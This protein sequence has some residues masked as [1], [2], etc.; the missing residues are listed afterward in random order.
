VL[1]ESRPHW[2][3]KTQRLESDIAKITYVKTQKVWKLY[4]MRQD[5]K[6]HRYE[7]FES[8][9]LLQKILTIVVKDEFGCFFG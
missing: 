1:F 2:Q 6:W 7:P 5:L 8:D 9:K 3:D 4:W